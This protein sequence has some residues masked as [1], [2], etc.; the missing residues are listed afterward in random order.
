MSKWP[1]SVFDMEDGTFIVECIEHGPL[2]VL[3][4]SFADLA[5]FIKN[6]N[7]QFPHHVAGTHR[8]R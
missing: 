4:C 3:K 7:E 1:V 6:H 5:A 2:G 8:L